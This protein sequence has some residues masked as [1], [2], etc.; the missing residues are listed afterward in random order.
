MEANIEEK[1][2]YRGQVNYIF[3]KTITMYPCELI[4]TE[5]TMLLKTKVPLMHSSITI[6]IKDITKVERRN[7]FKFVPSRLRIY[8]MDGNEHTIST[9][10]REGICRALDKAKTV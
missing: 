1:I 10:D 8:T 9:W 5:Q 4:I 2:F 6:S 3:D 7:V